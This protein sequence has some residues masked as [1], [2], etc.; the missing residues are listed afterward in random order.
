MV[1]AK[2][3]VCV[4]RRFDAHVVGSDVV[5]MLSFMAREMSDLVEGDVEEASSRKSWFVRRERECI[6]VRRGPGKC[7]QRQSS[8][9]NTNSASQ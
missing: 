6:R 5:A 9:P 8:L 1:A 3:E 4:R 2:G 7:K